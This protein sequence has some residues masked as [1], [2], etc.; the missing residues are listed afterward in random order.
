MKFLFKNHLT[1]PQPLNLSSPQTLLKKTKLKK[2][3]SLM[4]D[5]SNT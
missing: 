5:P 2:H 4:L 1:T 3:M